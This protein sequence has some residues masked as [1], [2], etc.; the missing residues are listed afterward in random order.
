MLSRHL[1]YGPDF[2]CAV[3][4]DLYSVLAETAVHLIA[5]KTSGTGALSETLLW[6]H[7]LSNWFPLTLSRQLLGSACFS[8]G[9]WL[10]ESSALVCAWFQIYFRSQHSFVAPS[11]WDLSY[12]FFQRCLLFFQSQLLNLAKWLFS[13]S[14]GDA[15]WWVCPWWFQPDRLV[16]PPSAYSLSEE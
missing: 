7:S 13:R 14:R 11:A 16:S 3:A 2:R 5:G 15:I 8:A 4:S 10:T 6:Q 1:R 9:Q 12:C